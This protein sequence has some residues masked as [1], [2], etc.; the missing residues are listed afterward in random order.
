[1]RTIHY[2]FVVFM[3][4][5]LFF[6]S[7]ADTNDGTYVAPISVAEKIHGTW[8][9]ISV[10][11]TDEIAKTAGQTP[12]D[13]GLSRQF[14][15]TSFHVAFN[16]DDKNNPTSYTITGDA[17]ALIPTSGYWS[18]PNLFINTDA[19]PNEIYLFTDQAKTQ[20]IAALTL[21]SVPGLLDVFEFKLTRRTNGVAF[22]S[23]TYRLCK[24]N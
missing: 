23:Y 13:L 9:A 11:Q 18:M 17:P 10:K 20:K 16:A 7:C 24:V 6:S 12:T 21:G 14:N 15:F 3:T 4:M 22:V 2:Y 19:T 5:T 8:A 1:M